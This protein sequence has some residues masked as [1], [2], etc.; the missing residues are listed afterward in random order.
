MY[1]WFKTKTDYRIIN[2]PKYADY[3]IGDIAFE[4]DLG[5]VVIITGFTVNGKP[6][7]SAHNNPR[8]N[9]PIYSDIKYLVKLSE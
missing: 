7:F 5:H 8:L 1:Y 2:S 6:L 3:S 9:R 4:S